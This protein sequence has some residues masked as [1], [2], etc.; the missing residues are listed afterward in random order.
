MNLIL[1]RCGLIIIF[2]RRGLLRLSL[3]AVVGL[4]LC[5]HVTELFD[6]WDHTV[7]TGSDMDYSVVLLAASAGLAIVVARYLVSILSRSKEEQTSK[8]DDPLSVALVSFGNASDA[9]LSPPPLLP[10]RV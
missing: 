3:L 6:S 9:G 10:L 4:I 8:I 2:M 5:G 7:A 1:N